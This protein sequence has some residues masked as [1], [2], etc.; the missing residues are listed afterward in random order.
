MA[1]HALTVFAQRIHG[2]GLDV[3][4]NVVDDQGAEKNF[5]VTRDNSIILQRHDLTNPT[6]TVQIRAEGKGCVMVQV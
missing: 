6:S 3:S 4:L 5:R 2:T 1:L